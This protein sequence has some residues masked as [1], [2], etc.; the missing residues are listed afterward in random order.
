MD[1]WVTS[2]LC[3]M[4]NV[5]RKPVD[6][7]ISEIIIPNDDCVI[8][9]YI[10]EWQESGVHVLGDYIFICLLIYFIW[11]AF[12]VR[13][14]E[15]FTIRRWKAW[16]FGGSLAENHLL[17]YSCARVNNPWLDKS[18]HATLAELYN[19]RTYGILGGVKTIQKTHPQVD[20]HTW[21]CAL[22]GCL[23]TMSLSLVRNQSPTRRQVNLVD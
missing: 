15:C 11:S 13:I 3:K 22:V 10:N 23:L 17:S 12:I 2:T 21:Y 6:Y 14:R 8:T 1:V 20:L 9:Y 18:F 5:V 7:A 4:A 16:W 19:N